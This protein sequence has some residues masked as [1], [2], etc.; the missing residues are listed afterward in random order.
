MK[1]RHFILLI[2]IS[3]CALAVA[4]RGA[5]LK[6]AVLRP[7]DLYQDK[8]VFELPFLMHS[9]DFLRFMVENADELRQMEQE[10]TA[11]TVATRPTQSTTRQDQATMP[12]DSTTQPSDSATQPSHSTSVPSQSTLPSESTEPS[13]ESSPEATTTA[14][15]TSSTTP[16]TTV[17]A[18]VGPN[19][20][21][22]SGVDESWFD[23]VLFI[24]DSR[25]VGLREYARSGNAEYFCD[26]G[27]TVFSYKDK[28]LSDRNFTSQTLDYLLSNRQYDK[29]IINFGLNEA[30]YPLSSFQLAYS[31]FVDMVRQ[32]QPHAIIILQGVMS[33]TRGMAA[34]ASYFTPA[35]LGQMSAYIQ[36]RCD[37]QTIYYI[38]C[39]AYF[40]DEEGYLYNSITNDGY[41]P[42]GSGYRHWRDWI[43]FALEE[44]GL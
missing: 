19:F 12:S 17:P 40:A 20:E 18:P 38:D 11:P 7:L 16:P 8:S 34:T 25:V 6:F 33:V 27:M 37:G 3:I 36:S 32:K 30:G 15:T 31:K 44:I 29:I 21:F 35:Y 43:S 1:M 28:S 2:A 4:C 24:G 39:N 5:Y 42:T 9:D 10:S 23:N 22:P 13:Q 26:V 14:P 41:H